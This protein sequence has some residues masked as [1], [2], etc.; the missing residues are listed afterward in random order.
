[1]GKD[2][3]RCVCVF[4]YD[5]VFVYVRACVRVCVCVCVLD[6]ISKPDNISAVVSSANSNLKHS[7]IHLC[8]G[9]GSVREVGQCVR[10]GAVCVRGGAVC[11]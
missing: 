8:E 1:M 7:C 3:A 10:G 4:V 6:A 2:R 9:W 11:V 5:C